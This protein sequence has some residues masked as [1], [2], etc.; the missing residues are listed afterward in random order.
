M[1]Y[2]VS[3]VAEMSH[4]SVRTLHHYDEIRLL[5]PGRR[6]DAGYRLYDEADLER[7]QQILIFRELGFELSRIRQVMDEPGY[8]RRSALLGQ[9]ELLEARA[10]RL[11]AMIDA[12]DTA[13]D[14]EEKGTTMSKD[15]MFE[16]FDDFDPGE[17][18]DEAKERWGDTDA[19]NESVRRT[20]QYTREDWERYKNE[21]DEINSAIAG[22]MDE[23]IPASDPRA[24]DAVEKA[25]LQIDQWF[26]PC[27]RQ[28]HAEL[29]KMYV[30][31]PRF[32]ETY[33]KIRPGMAQ[34]MCDATSANAERGDA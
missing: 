7:L 28:M 23:G 12:V 30:A 8:D 9:R 2:T 5:V 24:M 11:L 6:S 27:S 1:S 17:H 15:E 4:V 29:G 3:Q 10:A 32:T 13:I 20:S 19:Y 16:V 18:E 31:D 14:H 25:R 22:L 33:E 26:Y 21:A 34:Y